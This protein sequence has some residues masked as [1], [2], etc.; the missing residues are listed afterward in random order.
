MP[1]IPKHHLVR[2]C[3]F[4]MTEFTENRAGVL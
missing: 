4:P 2:S 3:M 1:G